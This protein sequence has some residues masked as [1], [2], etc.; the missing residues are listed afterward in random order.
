MRGKVKQLINDHAV[1][2]INSVMATYMIGER[3]FYF[4]NLRDHVQAR[5]DA[6]RRLHADGLSAAD[7]VRITGFSE[8]TVFARIHPDIRE[9][10]NARRRKGHDPAKEARA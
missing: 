7:I 10:R 3:E 1:S 8:N 4:S 6:I 9:L 5:A 2:V